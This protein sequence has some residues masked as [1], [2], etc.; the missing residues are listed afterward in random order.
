MIKIWKGIEK[1]SISKDGE[2]MTMFVC[3]NEPVTSN[4]VTSMLLANPDIRAV[5]FGAGRKEFV[6]PNAKEWD[7]ILRYCEELDIRIVIEVSPMTLPLFARL[8]NH[9]IITLIVA[10]YDAPKNL[11]NLYFKTDDFNVTKIFAVE[12]SVDITGVVEDRY[13][14]DVLL[15]TED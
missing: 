10:Y 13:A 14:D 4:L 1:E 2:V 6:I 5:Y 11:N 8:F 12:K 7:K 3:S 15:Y 9:S